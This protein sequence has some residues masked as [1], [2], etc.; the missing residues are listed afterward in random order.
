MTGCLVEHNKKIL[1]CK[2]NIEPRKGLWT[3]PA[4]FMEDHE[5]SAEGAARETYEETLADVSIDEL[6]AFY[7]IPHIS[8]IYM[9]YRAHLKT[10]HYGPTAESS[11]VVLMTESEI[12]WSE[13]AFPVIEK[14]LKHFY[15]SKKTGKLETHFGI[16]D[17]RNEVK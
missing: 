9:I 11:E 7:D 17:R 15:A 1:L 16:I 13:I 4:G 3:L 6:F 5:T 10:E 12:P 14:T 2:R 8:Q